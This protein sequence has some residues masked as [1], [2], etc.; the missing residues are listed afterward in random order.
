MP[1]VEF[2]TQEIL[3]LLGK[4]YDIDYLRD[5]IPMI[6]VSLESFDNKKTVIEAF[7]NRPDLLSVEGLTRALRGFL[8]IETGFRKYN[9]KDSKIK[10]HID[11]SVKNIRPHI[12]S[13]IIKNVFLDGQRLKSLMDLQE[14][15]HLTPGRNRE[16]AAIGVHDLDR[17]EA[18]F[19]Y[20]AVKPDEISFIP[21]DMN[22]S[23]NLRQI[24]QRHPK[25]RD[26]AWTLKDFDR[27]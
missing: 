16:N 22:E 26:Y 23:L 7:P 24:L 21:L 17:I 11:S 2:D 1:N 19:L 5:R 3:K 10:L 18:P 20:K 12:A 9:L 6:G 27:Y 15:L 13:G 8:D 4:D 14:K 25:G